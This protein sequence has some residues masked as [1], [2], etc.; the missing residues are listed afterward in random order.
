MEIFYH[1]Y[2][3]ELEDYNRRLST[4]Q[5]ALSFDEFKSKCEIDIEFKKQNVY[6]FHPSIRTDNNL[7]FKMIDFLG[8]WPVNAKSV[9]LRHQDNRACY[10]STDKDIRNG[11]NTSIVTDDEYYWWKLSETKKNEF[12]KEIYGRIGQDFLSKSHKL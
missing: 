6:L 1:H 11:W 5:V 2:K 3:S 10:F 9:V 8:G 7:F 4:H 12:R